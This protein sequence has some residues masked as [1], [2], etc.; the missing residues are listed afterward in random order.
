VVGQEGPAAASHPPNLTRVGGLYRYNHPRYDNMAF[1]WAVEK[2]KA[3]YPA[4][5]A[6]R[7]RRGP[8]EETAPRAAAPAA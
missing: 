2:V 3:R 1:L 6:W 7:A 5:A 4:E 8:G